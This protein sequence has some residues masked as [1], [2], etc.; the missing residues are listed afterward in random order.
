M[1]DLLNPEYSRKIYQDRLSETV[2]P[3]SPSRKA[4]FKNLFGKVKIPKPSWRKLFFCLIGLLIFL[5]L[6]FF[7]LLR[8]A[9]S[10]YTGIKNTEV[11]VSE[12]QTAFAKKDLTVVEHALAKLETELAKMRGSYQRLRYLKKIP[13]ISGY[14][15]DGEHL[16][17]AASLS[18]EGGKEL[19]DAISSFSD[20]LGLTEGFG[21]ILTT[22]Q[23]AIS[24]ARI[25]PRITPQ[26]DTALGKLFLVKVELE[27]I[28]PVH[29]PEEIRGMKLRFW[30]QEVKKM[31]SEFE[32]F[33]RETRTIVEVLP[34]LLGVPERTYLVL[35]QNDAELR[36]TG[37]FITAFGLVTVKDGRVVATDQ[38]GI[39]YANGRIPYIRPPDPLRRY[40]K[41]HTWHLSD[42]N[43]SPDFKLSARKA[44]EMWRM[45]N[46]PQTSFVVAITTEAA[47]EML[48][49]IGPVKLPNYP[50]D[51]SRYS[52]L[53]S[54]CRAG[55]DRFTATNLVCRLEY[56][57]EKFRPDIA[58]R[59]YDRKLILGDL[60]DAIINKIT[61][62][63]VE[64][65]PKLLDF[66][67]TLLNQ[68]NILLYSTNPKEQE[69]IEKLG[70]AG[71]IKDYPSA[72]STSSEQAGSGQAAGD[73][74][75]ISDSNFGGKKTD[76]YMREGVEQSL[77]RLRDG[78]W[79]KTV[80]INYFNPQKYDNWLSANYKDFVRLL[81]PKGSKLVKIEGASQQ[82][83]SWNEVGK[84][85]FGAFFT[86][87]PQKE[88]TL[89]FVYDLPEGSVGENYQLLMQ[90]QPGT[91]ITLVKVK[92]GDKIESFELKT[93]R[94]ITVDY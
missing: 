5:G 81:V 76:L 80:K 69:L 51:L 35:F 6:G 59:K 61:S 21:K 27:E 26:I 32:P 15:R 70:Y 90:K 29:Y 71:R 28:N 93:D 83:G 86:L 19:L 67:F 8:P 50:Y 22:E 47:R 79:R 36:A 89:T 94:E 14:Y 88:H 1:I 82:W 74:L 44:V 53:P 7:F 55:G 54:D 20:V 31:I 2:A 87:L 73:Y 10:L 9:F 65:R 25:L 56:Y 63:S 11:V 91:N 43:F 60:M 37:G 75:H 23:Q 38:H 45:T 33:L 17:G 62:S 16:L 68:K 24:L 92:I 58:A 41:V 4:G 48:E 46:L 72:H 66:T 18:A 40:L 77:V 13:V 42:S 49:F 64:I 78:R 57:V 52:W 34:H 84:T 30:L 39:G 3:Q 85:V 12:L